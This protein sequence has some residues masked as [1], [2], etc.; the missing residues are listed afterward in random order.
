[1]AR[2][3]SGQGLV[4]IINPALGQPILFAVRPDGRGDV[5]NSHVVWSRQRAVPLTP[6]PLIVGE[7]LY[8]ASDNGVATCL[9]AKTGQEHWTMR[10]NGNFSASPI[11]AGGWIYFLNETGETTVIKPG[12]KFERL[13]VNRLDGATLASMAVAG[14]AIFVRTDSCLY[15]IEKRKGK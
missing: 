7:E 2:P 1:M 15:R 5:M 8:L 4:Y 11:Y 10:L 12:R 9:D 13:A 14:R 6:S 3:V